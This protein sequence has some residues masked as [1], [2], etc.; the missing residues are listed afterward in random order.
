MV[1][2]F[3]GSTNWCVAYTRRDVSITTGNPPVTSTLKQYPL[4]ANHGD[5]RTFDISQKSVV[6]N[7]VQQWSLLFP[8]DTYSAWRPVS[9]ALKIRCCNNDEENDGWFEAVRTSRN[10]FLD[11]FG[12]TINSTF[13][14]NT[15]PNTAEPSVDTYLQI[16]EPRVY[17]GSVLPSKKTVEKWLY[18]TEWYNMATYCTGELKDIGDV[19]F[20]LNNEKA[21]NDFKKVCA[22]NGQDSATNAE[23][24]T[25]IDYSDTNPRESVGTVSTLAVTELRI[26]KTHSTD[27][28]A[29]GTLPVDNSLL[30]QYQD[31]FLSD[32][33]DIIIIRIHGIKETRL[34]LHSVANIEL[35]CGEFSQIAQ[36]QTV[37]YSDLDALERYIEKRNSAYKLPFSYDNQY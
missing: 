2:L 24:I 25:V 4:L 26:P 23:N 17:L 1:V 12:V 27:V 18:D 36:Y 21:E 35:M 10:T 19:M 22:F 28:G 33:M 6:H 15:D 14:N 31:T 16:Y 8:S 13:A 3:P 29:S 34:L 30:G 11:E 20:Q 5:N 37:C 32:S 7:G 9:Y